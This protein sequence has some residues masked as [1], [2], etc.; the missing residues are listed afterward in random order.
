MANYK[1]L[2]NTVTFFGA[3]TN[4]LDEDYNDVLGYSTRGRNFKIGV[5][6]QF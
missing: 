1:L 4:L 5:R 2:D 6:L 3:V